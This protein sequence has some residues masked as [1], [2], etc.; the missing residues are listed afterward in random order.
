MVQPDLDPDVAQQHALRVRL[1]VARRRGV[2]R[3]HAEE[4]EEAHDRAAAERDRADRDDRAHTG[5]CGRPSERN[6]R[7]AAGEPPDH[8]RRHDH[9]PTASSAAARATPNAP[10]MPA[11]SERRRTGGSMRAANR[12]ASAP[13]AS[14]PRSWMP[15]YDGSLCSGRRPWNSFTRP[16]NWSA[17]MIT[18]TLV[19]R[20]TA[21]RNARR[22]ARVRNASAVTGASTPYSTNFSPLTRWLLTEYW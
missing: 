8:D 5:E 2:V 17:A 10:A 14:A 9:P 4:A 3:L 15:M 20:A 21:H 12:N 7:A 16:R 1:D 6:P 22:S 18:K 13:P 19:Q 11:T